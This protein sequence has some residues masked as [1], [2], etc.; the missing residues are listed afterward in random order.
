MEPKANYKPR[1]KSVVVKRPITF[2]ATEEQ[3][4]LLRQHIKESCGNLSFWLN[5]AVQNQLKAEG[6]K[7]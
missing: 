5:R 1:L 3:D 2:Y 6:V 7:L 4:I